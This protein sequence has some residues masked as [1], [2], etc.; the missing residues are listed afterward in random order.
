VAAL[1]NSNEFKNVN[2]KNEKVTFLYSDYLECS[3]YIHISIRFI[4][5]SIERMRRCILQNNGHAAGG[6]E[7]HL[8]VPPIP[9]WQ[10]AQIPVQLLPTNING[11]HTGVDHLVNTGG[12]QMDR[13][14]IILKL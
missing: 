9:F 5:L 7:F 13:K 6:N 14:K 12:D 11:H 4:D 8:D 3:K 2:N 1:A 10:N